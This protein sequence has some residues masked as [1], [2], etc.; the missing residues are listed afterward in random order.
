ML[1][2]Y[3]LRSLRDIVG[4]L[5]LIT[6][7]ILLIAFFNFIFSG[8]LEAMGRPEEGLSYLSILTIGFALTFQIYGASVSFEAL[9]MDFFT[10]MRDR[11]TATPTD[12]RYIVVSSLATGCIVSFLQTLAVLLFSTLVL[13]ADLHSFYLILPIMFISILFNQFLGTL[14]LILTRSIKSANIILTIYASVTPMT[15][16]LYFTLPKHAFFDILKT[17]L[18]PLA[19]ANTA[20][21]GVLKGN[22]TQALL[23]SGMLLILSCGLFLGLRPL[24]RRL[25]I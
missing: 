14:V 20:V 15:I 18:S 25:A 6:F 3:L 16:G 23:A 22:Q 10:P 7:P 21:V 13:K 5:I 4:H 1:K 11:L 9:G 24:I 17:Y 19:L 2:F 12:P 8:R